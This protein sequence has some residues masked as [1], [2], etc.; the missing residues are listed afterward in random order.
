MIIIVSDGAEEPRLDQIRN[1]IKKSSLQNNIEQ[2][3]ENLNKLEDLVQ[4]RKTDKNLVEQSKYSILKNALSYAASKGHN[5]AIEK[6]WRY[7]GNDISLFEFAIANTLDYKQEGAFF[8]ILDLLKGNTSLFTR[9]K[10]WTDRLFFMICNK[11]TLL[12][13]KALLPFVNPKINQSQY[14]RE[15]CVSGNEAIV[16][17]LVP[18][19]NIDSALSYL[20]KRKTI[21]KQRYELLERISEAKKLKHKMT[22]ELEETSRPKQNKKSKKM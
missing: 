11:G 10:G 21:D 19:S 4:T 18:Y 16:H 3:E 15:A 14:I 8:K 5:E 9:N 20:R 2:L 7:C 12:E 22:E 17:F 1:D 13:A 6:I